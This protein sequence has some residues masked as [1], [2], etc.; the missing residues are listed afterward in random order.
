MKT[1]SRFVWFNVYLNGRLIDE[2]CYI[3]SAN[4]DRA[5]VKK[6]LVEHDG[7]D[8]NIVVRKSR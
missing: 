4:V 8:P 1:L 3:R 5:E 2:I 6:S 7:Y